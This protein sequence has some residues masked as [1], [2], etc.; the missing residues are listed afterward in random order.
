MINRLIF[1]TA[2]SL[3]CF[4]GK[5]NTHKQV[6]DITPHES[7]YV[8]TDKE[9]YFAGDWLFFKTYLSLSNGYFGTLSSKVQYITLYS[10]QGTV[11]ANVELHSNNPNISGSLHLPDT[12]KSSIYLLVAWTNNMII[13]NSKLFAKQIII[14][15]RFDVSP[16]NSLISQETLINEDDTISDKQN[17][18]NQYI[19]K[20]KIIAIKTPKEK[21]NTRESV[22]ISF[23][24]TSLPKGLVSASISITRAETIFENNSNDFTLYAEDLFNSQPEMIVIPE[25]HGPILSGRVLEKKSNKSVHN[26]IVFLSSPDSLVNLKY[27]KTNEEGAFFFLLDEYYHNRP[28]S[29][30][31]YEQGQSETDYSIVV[32]NKFVPLNFSPGKLQLNS[33]LPNY[34]EEVLLVKRIQK[35]YGSSIIKKDEVFRNGIEIRPQVYASPLFSLET[36]TYVPL[37]SLVEIAHEIIP[38]LRIRSNRRGY[39]ANVV[40]QRTKDFLPKQPIFFLN[41]VY[42]EQIKDIAHLSSKELEKVEIVNLPWS[43]GDLEFHGVVS[44]LTKD[45][46]YLTDSQRKTISNNDYSHFEGVSF[47]IPINANSPESISQPDL[48]ETL[49]WIPNLELQNG[50]PKDVTYL[51]SDILGYYTIAFEGICSNG[52]IIKEK[53]TFK[54]E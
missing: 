39:T 49:L 45:R 44:L 33:K 40:N 1:I 24:S 19:H 12:L 28:I 2:L 42:V 9:I 7:I 25:S 31:L 20:S 36:S 37:D 17:K 5:S 47:S 32:R 18:A 48:R 52:Q 22:E 14:V 34:I 11:V 43:F 50:V 8:H 30:Q 26:A 46:K 35:A 3:L 38:V 23:N 10:Q 54:V 21:I 16:L 6:A 27:F 13:S 53:T 4:L 41:G 15:N 51:T 29:L